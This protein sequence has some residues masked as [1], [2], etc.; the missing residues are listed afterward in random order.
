[1]PLE[2]KIQ[3]LFR[4]KED[5]IE[6]P[7]NLFRQLARADN[8]IFFKSFSPYTNYSNGGRD[9]IYLIDVMGDK[10]Y[11]RLLR[12]CISGS[13]ISELEKYGA[14]IWAEHHFDRLDEDLFFEI[15]IKFYRLDRD[16]PYPL[17]YPIDKFKLFK[18]VCDMV[19][20]DRVDGS[21]LSEFKSINLDNF[22]YFF[23]AIPPGQELVNYLIY[24][25][26]QLLNERILRDMLKNFQW[27]E[28]LINHVD[29]EKLILVLD[30]HLMFPNFLKDT[31]EAALGIII[32]FRSSIM[33]ST[34]FQDKI[35][36][37]T[38]SK[39]LVNLDI[40]DDRVKNK[41]I[42]K[43]VYENMIKSKKYLG[44]N[45][46]D[47]SDILNILD[48]LDK[49]QME[50]QLLLP[51]LAQKLVRLVSLSIFLEMAQEYSDRR[52]IKLLCEA[53][54]DVNIYRD[55]LRS[56]E[57]I[58]VFNP[59]FKIG[60]FKKL[61]QLHDYLSREAT[62]LK[63]KNFDLD[64]GLEYLDNKEFEGYRIIVP[65]DSYS[66]IDAGLS[67]NICVGNG[68]YSEKVLG[69]KSKIVLLSKNNS[70]IGC[71]EFDSSEIV[72]SKGASNEPLPLDPQKFIDFVNV[73]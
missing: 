7:F 62:R 15:I 19:Y 11:S 41:R 23:K 35:S 63:S 21:N 29:R 61:K 57:R 27:R 5:G 44:L 28:F 36:C 72:Q 43:N 22:K 55:T 54:Q 60:R 6:A 46:I 71:V 64:Q 1:M 14:P 16:N 31:E 3:I 33:V 50:E 13:D 32:P 34:Y 70:L 53:K 67:L 69:K 30:Y 18:K 73:S 49:R 17:K 65:K 56:Y 2:E 4:M 12:E 39:I 8:L 45:I 68:Y 38:H 59:E 42:K 51:L 37:Y 48:I 47:I 20:S 58:K 10:R 52:I 9:N 25:H 66:L 26:R 24:H 40:F